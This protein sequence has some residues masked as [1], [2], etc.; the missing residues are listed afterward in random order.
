M[1]QEAIA[2]LRWRG[3]CMAVLDAISMHMDIEMITKE[4]QIFAD[5]HSR[6]QVKSKNQSNLA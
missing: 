5:A 6:N 3:R 4:E 2:T 1:F